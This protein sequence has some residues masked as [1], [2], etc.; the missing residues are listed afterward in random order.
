MHHD[1]TRSICADALR[2]SQ[3]FPTL[4]AR[5][6][7]MGNAFTSLGVISPP[8]ISIRPVWY[9]QKIGNA[10]FPDGIFN[11]KS[12]YL[13]QGVTDDQYQYINSSVG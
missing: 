5:S 3:N 11:I 7:S 12:N 2:F 4:T 8:P 6:M 1:R 13:G 10:L 9:L